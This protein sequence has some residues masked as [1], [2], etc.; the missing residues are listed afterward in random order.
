[1]KY[2][3]ELKLICITIWYNTLDRLICSAK[4]I[5]IEFHFKQHDKTYIYM[6]IMDTDTHK[7]HIFNNFL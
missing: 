2:Y 6:K 4:S 7:R 1:M 3:F 5:K